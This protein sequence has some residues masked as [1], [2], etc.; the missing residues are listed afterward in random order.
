MLI[1]DLDLDLFLN[2]IAYNKNDDWSRLDDDEF[3][4]D[5][6]EFVR[7][8]L[9]QRCHLTKEKP[10]K[11]SSVTFHGEVFG[12]VDFLI[13]EGVLVPPFYWVHADA[14]DDMNGAFNEDTPV[15]SDNY[16]LHL[17]RNGWLKSL[18]FVCHPADR[19]LMNVKENPLRVDIGP[20]PVPVGQFLKF[21]NPDSF[22]DQYY[23]DEF[24]LE[25]CP[26][27][28][29]VAHSPSFTPASADP[30]FELIKAYIK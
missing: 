28:V 11:G 25:R 14:H 8:F 12:K 21:R 7:H 18:R 10:C 19:S 3:G 4:P 17:A 2:A 5:S 26:D 16:I 22:T 6:E 9:E 13:K 24:F 20:H 1:L 29:F 27:Y 30:L 15:R 23:Y